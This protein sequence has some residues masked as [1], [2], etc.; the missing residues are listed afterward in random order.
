MSRNLFAKTFLFALLVIFASAGVVRCGTSGWLG[1][2]VQEL[3]DSLKE[4]LDYKGDGVLVKE[5]YEDSPASKGGLSAGDIISKL[6]SEEVEDLGGFVEMVRESETGSMVDVTVVRKGKKKVLKIEIGERETSEHC[7]KF[8]KH[9]KGFKSLKFSSRAYLGVKI[10]DLTEELGEYFGTSEGALV[11]SVVEDSPATAAGFKTGDVIREID[12]SRIHDANDVFE[13]LEH[14]EG[15][16]EVDV[17]IVRKGREQTLKVT[18]DEHKGKAIFKCI[19][20]GGG[21]KNLQCEPGASWHGMPNM[22]DFDIDLHL[23]NLGEYLDSEEFEKD[24][25]AKVHII[26]G[27]SEKKIEVLKE[28]LEELGEKLKEMEKKLS[29]N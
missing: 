10:E 3:D 2:E 26:E 5:V 29:K 6:G 18:L 1:V 11:M 24:I 4:A 16:E 27:L 14:K 8:G 12:G 9:F 20:G 13:V 7:G 17:L 21:H 22:E 19:P 15:G 23:G 25:E 28:K